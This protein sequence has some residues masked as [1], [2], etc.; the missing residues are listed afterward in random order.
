MTLTFVHTATFTEA[1]TSLRLRDEQLQALEQG[2]LD[3]PE[4]G[5]VMPGC[6][7]MRKIRVGVTGRGKRGGARV[8]YAHFRT[9]AHV[10]LVLVYAKNEQENISASD[11]KSLRELMRSIETY[12]EEQP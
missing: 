7:G 2:L 6:G 10:Y 1:W 8:V 5:D 9:H 3:D 11:K 12:L 4:R